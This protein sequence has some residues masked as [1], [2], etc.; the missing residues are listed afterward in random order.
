MKMKRCKI[1]NRE[2]KLFH[3]YCEECKIVT[4]I[5]NDQ[6]YYKKNRKKFFKYHKENFVN[7]PSFG[8]RKGKVTT[9]FT[10]GMTEEMKK[11]VPK[12]KNKVLNDCIKNPRKYL[13]K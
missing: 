10:N 4:K 7:I 13:G 12:I 3:K 1:C 2:R 11:L 9:V 5:T 8:S 6:R